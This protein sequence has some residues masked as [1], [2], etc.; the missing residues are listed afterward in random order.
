MCHEFR[1]AELKG[2]GGTDMVMTTSSLLN[3]AVALAA[4]PTGSNGRLSSAVV[5]NRGPVRKPNHQPRCGRAPSAP[6]GFTT[7]ESV[8][9]KSG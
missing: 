4:S 7:L 6:R 5:Y 2:C 9:E 3:L 8:P 1:V